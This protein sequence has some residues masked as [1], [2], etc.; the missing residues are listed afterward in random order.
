MRNIRLLD[1][2]V[3]PVDRCGADGGVLRIRILP[4]FVIADVAARFTDP[5]KTAKIEH[6]FDG[7]ETDHVTYEHYTVFQ[8][9][10]ADNGK[11]LLWMKQTNQSE[12][13]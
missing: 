11:L 2:T 13:G 7:V 12:G 9:M 5:T 8:S 10:E 4:P 3:Y 1:G 6:Y